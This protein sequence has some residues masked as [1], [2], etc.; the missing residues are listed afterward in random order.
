MKAAPADRLG[1]LS[2]ASATLEEFSLLQQLAAG[3]GTSNIDHRLRQGDFSGDAADP[4]LPTLGGSIAEVDA[5]QALL[6]VGANLRHE[7]PLLAHRVR[8]AATAGAKVWF[9]N[10][11]AYE[12]LF[13]VAGQKVVAPDEQ[14]AELNGLLAAAGASTI[15][16]VATLVTD[17]HQSI[18]E[19]L[20][21][22][23][24][25]AI[26]L[27][28]LS[29]RHPQYAALRAAGQALAV[30][31]GA[32][33]GV[34]AEGGNAAGAHLAGAVPHR[35]AGGVPRARAGFNAAQ[36]LAN[37]LEAYLLWDMEPDADTLHP[38]AMAS[39]RAATYVVA[40]TPYVTE[41]LKSIAHVLLPIGTFA[42]TSG[43]YVNLEGAWQSFTGAAVPVGEAR[44]GWKVL[45]VLGNLLAMSGFEQ[46]SSEEVRDALRVL[47]ERSAAPGAAVAPISVA[48][49]SGAITVTDVPIYQSD[50]IVRRASALQRT[51][52]AALP[53]KVYGA[54]AA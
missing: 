36:M 12:F 40:A 23:Q 6:V 11:E 46:N 17:R 7:L 9:V 35:G 53:R 19:A 10:P 22:A 30:A 5:L 24:R 54:P 28:A 26:W 50:A 2:G 37:P 43:T 15:G 21:G 39:L 31:T 27:G 44:P 13:P 45:R 18:V 33:F 8:K 14:L 42:E 16:A 32:S 29:L 34:L 51:R 20:R 25:K 1:F 52:E 3:L 48:T 41:A 38:K 4:A 47:V 49:V